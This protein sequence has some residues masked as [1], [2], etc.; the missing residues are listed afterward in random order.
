MLV[1][2]HRRNRYDF[3]RRQIRGNRRRFGE[4][5]HFAQRDGHNPSGFYPLHYRS[6][7]N[8]VLGRGIFLDFQL[9]KFEEVKVVELLAMEIRDGLHLFA[10]L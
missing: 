10:G 2:L 4:G 3:S 1:A 5:T 9:L 8:G 7:K 6:L